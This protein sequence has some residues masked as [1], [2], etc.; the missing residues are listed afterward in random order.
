M[1]FLVATCWNK[2]TNLHKALNTTF[3]RLFTTENSPLLPAMSTVE[4]HKRTRKPS[5]RVRESQ[6]QTYEQIY[7]CSK[8][9]E[10]TEE[11]TGPPAKKRSRSR[12][13]TST[14]GNTAAVSKA[15][16]PRTYKQ[17]KEKSSG[18]KKAEGRSNKGKKKR[19]AGQS[20][21]PL[22]A[23]TL[24]YYTSLTQPPP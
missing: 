13:R 9:F 17:S 24:S 5:I 6:G 22:P 23:N 18:Q 19:P 3:V 4:A 16:A 12:P 8:G 1:L 10:Q 20:I 7:G 2:W 15:T 21:T 11:S 14:R